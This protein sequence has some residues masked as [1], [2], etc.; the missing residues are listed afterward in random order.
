MTEIE[1]KA[2]V[3]DPDSTE[4]A[5]AAFAE[6]RKETI[7]NDTYWRKILAQPVGERAQPVEE[8][9]RSSGPEMAQSRTATGVDVS[10]GAQEP[11]QVK[12]RIRDENGEV[13]V[14]YKRKELQGDIEVNDEREFGISDRFPFEVLLGDLGF[15]PYITKEKR[16]RSFAWISPEGMPLTI[17]LS[18]VGGLGWFVELEILAK[19]PDAAETAKAQGILRATLERCGI[20]ASAIEPRYYTDMLA[21]RN[22][23]RV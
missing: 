19:D 4:R 8:G 17:E 11:K 23:Q 15:R 2:H 10:T 6:F 14:T 20:P 1:I 5:I 16:T 12:V 18:L 3:A 13:I 22:G 7:K 21:E 9:A